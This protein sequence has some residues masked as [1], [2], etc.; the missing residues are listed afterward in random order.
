ME[1]KNHIKRPIDTYFL[2][3]WVFQ[4]ITLLQFGFS[5][6]IRHIAKLGLIVPFLLFAGQS[7]EQTN[8]YLVVV[9]MGALVLVNCRRIELTEKAIFLQVKTSGQK[10]KTLQ[11]MFEATNTPI[12]RLDRSGRFSYCN[13]VWAARALHQI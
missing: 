5:V 11:R 4:A 12:F 7:W 6:E 1:L 3:F 13:E 2:F 10:F 8:V 9:I